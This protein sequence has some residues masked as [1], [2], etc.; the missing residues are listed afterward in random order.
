MTRPDVLHIKR[1]CDLCQTALWTHNLDDTGY[2]YH[3]DLPMYAQ[4][5]SSQLK[6]P[7][8]GFL[9]WVSTMSK[10]QAALSSLL[11][12]LLTLACLCSAQL[13]LC[14]YTVETPQNRS[15]G[16]CRLICSNFKMERHKMSIYIDLLGKNWQRCTVK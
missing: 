10:A 13:T 12:G 15:Q 9:L 8:P 1:T 5:F 4:S 2:R 7:G 16:P 3:R 6:I 14:R 11:A